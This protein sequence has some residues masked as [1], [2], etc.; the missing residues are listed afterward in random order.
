[1]A[2]GDADLPIGE[3]F[4]L[5]PCDVLRNAPALL[6]CKRGHD[7]DQQLPF[8][9]KCP[10]IFL[11]KIALA[12]LFLQLPDGGKAVHGVPCEAGDALGHN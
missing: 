3:P 7:G 9:V 12:A 4:P 11:F 10:D 2:V 8:G 1:M 5:P 6:L